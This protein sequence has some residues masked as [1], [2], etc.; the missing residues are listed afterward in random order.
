MPD[1]PLG[2]VSVTVVSS[3]KPTDGVNVAVLP[4]TFQEPDVDGDTLGSGV[5]AASGAEN[6]TVIGLVPV[7]LCELE[8]GV[9]EV[10]SSA[11]AGCTVCFGAGLVFWPDEPEL[12]CRDEATVVLRS[13]V[14]PGVVTSTAT[15]A[16]TTSAAAMPVISRDLLARLRPVPP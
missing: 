10:I 16:I 4:E 6:P 7:T 12:S 2:M 9:T 5:L 13:M 8:P 15:P 3:G 11:G 1:E 14:L